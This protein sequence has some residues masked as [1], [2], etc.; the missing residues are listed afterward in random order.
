MWLFVPRARRLPGGGEWALP[1]PPSRVGFSA[2]P[3]HLT[4]GNGRLPPAL[5]GLGYPQG[6]AAGPA[7]LPA[8][9]WEPRVCACAPV[10]ALVRG[11]GHKDF[12]RATCFPV[13]FG[14]RVSPLAPT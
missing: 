2:P 10:R 6:T 7:E 12:G 1:L 9:A 5:Q 14:T 13:S 8:G 4:P 11:V 3:V